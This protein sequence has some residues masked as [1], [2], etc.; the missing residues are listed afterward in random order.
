MSCLSR[1]SRDRLYGLLGRAISDIDVALFPTEVH[2]AE[3]TEGAHL[4]H[5][6]VRRLL[7]LVRGDG[8][9]AGR[10]ALEDVERLPRQNHVAVPGPVDELR[11]VVGDVADDLARRDLRL[12]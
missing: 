5:V 6:D 8:G 2:P 12:D 10:R 11:V 4:E 3:R 9:V 7:R 1:A